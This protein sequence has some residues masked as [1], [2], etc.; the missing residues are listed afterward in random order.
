LRDEV[1][2]R[3]QKH[4]V[5]SRRQSVLSFYRR[6]AAAIQ[7]HIRPLC[8]TLPQ[9]PLRS[10]PQP[11]I[12]SSRSP[13]PP[14]AV[15]TSRH[16]PATSA[17]SSILAPKAAGSTAAS[18]PRRDSGAARRASRRSRPPAR[19]RREREG[20]S[21]REVPVLSVGPQPERGAE[22]VAV[23][24]THHPA[25]TQ[26]APDT[27]DAA[28]GHAGTPYAHPHSPPHRASASPP[29]SV[30]MS[31]PPPPTPVS[32]SATN[33]STRLGGAW[34]STCGWAHGWMDA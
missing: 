30:A 18:W 26:P 32:A 20:G 25:C 10:P 1:E 29:S 12:P 11:C 19:L 28:G 2:S 8:A 33:L 17:S 15:R 9:P 14:L 24:L 27:A 13:S 31:P 22:E 7:T 5:E 34:R 6:R 21:R 3:R 23:G 16:T 4:K